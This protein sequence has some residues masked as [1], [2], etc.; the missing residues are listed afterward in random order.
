M[1]LFSR[2]I[3]GWTVSDRLH[4]NLALAAMRQAFVIRRLDV[5]LNR[6]GFPEALIL[7]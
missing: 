4:R 1:D 3:I 7:K 2:R 5:G 6:P